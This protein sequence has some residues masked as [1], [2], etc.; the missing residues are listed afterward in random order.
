MHHAKMYMT[1]SSTDNNTADT[2][3]SSEIFHLCVSLDMRDT[4]KL[5]SSIFSTALEPSLIFLVK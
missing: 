2:A 1:A 5:F 4:R 3:L